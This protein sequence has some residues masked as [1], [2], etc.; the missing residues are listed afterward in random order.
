[1]SFNQINGFFVVV[2]QI[3]NAKN[4]LMLKTMHKT[5]GD[6]KQSEIY[7]E[8]LEHSQSGSKLGY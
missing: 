6:Y 5:K 1:M 8:T 4:E 7:K 2:E 3:S